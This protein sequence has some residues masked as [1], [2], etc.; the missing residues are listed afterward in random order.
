MQNK[1]NMNQENVKAQ[2]VDYRLRRLSRSTDTINN[3]LP[4][5]RCYHCNKAIS[6]YYQPSLQAEDLLKFFEAYNIERYCCRMII[7]QDYLQSRQ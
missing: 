3:D 2:T 7:L 5:M 4:P 6:F 1:V